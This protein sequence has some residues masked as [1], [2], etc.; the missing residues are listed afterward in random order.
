MKARSGL[1][2]LRVLAATAW[3]KG[4][5]GHTRNQPH[6]RQRGTVATRLSTLV[7]GRTR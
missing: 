6:H 3:A 4:E 1:D 2:G 5:H 7:V